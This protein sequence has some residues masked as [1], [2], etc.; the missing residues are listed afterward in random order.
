MG[1]AAA[2]LDLDASRV[3]QLLRSG[4]LA[5][6]RVGSVWLVDGDSLALVA[7]RRP[8]PRRPLAPAR[9]W[10]LLDLLDGGA[11]PDLSAV[12]R[13]QVRA[14]I[15]SLAGSD[16]SRWRAALRSRV[17]V[18][19]CQVHPAAV[20]RL[21]HEPGVLEAGPGKAA[22]HGLDLVAV[23]AVL[24]LYVRL[25]RWPALS[26]QYRVQPSRGSANLILHL[27]RAGHWPEPE[28]PR[29]AL[30]ADCVDSPE[31]RAGSA[32]AAMLNDLAFAVSRRPR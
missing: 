18:R 32:G 20:D 19:A 1:E 15:R 10:A 11:A 9:A 5:G 17:E 23:D 12:A 13:S 21:R 3:R 8:L 31:P 25:D 22:E 27:P 30:A 29:A 6:R 28:L 24:E 4:L 26:A 14:L 16:P 2:R 7:A